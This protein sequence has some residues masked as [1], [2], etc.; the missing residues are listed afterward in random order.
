MAVWQF[1]E[2]HKTAFA[3]LEFHNA[4]LQCFTNF[5]MACLYNCLRWAHHITPMRVWVMCPTMSSWHFSLWRPP[6]HICQEPLRYDTLIIDHSHATGCNFLPIRS[7]LVSLTCMWWTTTMKL[8]LLGV[9][10]N[11]SRVWRSYI[12]PL[13]LKRFCSGKVLTVRSRI[14]TSL[15][16]QRS[17]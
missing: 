12:Q 3:I 7:S 17:R 13:R 11:V 2:W 5:R 6:V 1:E 4:L 10:E 15:K 8:F 14:L 9:S 16:H